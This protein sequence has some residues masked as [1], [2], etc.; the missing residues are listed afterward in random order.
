MTGTNPY[1]LHL[2]LLISWFKATLITAKT[3]QNREC[4]KKQFYKTRIASL[5]AY[6]DSNYGW[7]RVKDIVQKA[8]VLTA[9]DQ[10]IVAPIVRWA[11]YKFN[12]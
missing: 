1:L 2:L 12:R 4:K 7:G 6:P 3:K 10:G 9:K 11:L 8:I 5:V